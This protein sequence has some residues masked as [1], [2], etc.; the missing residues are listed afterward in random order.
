MISLRDQITAILNAP[1]PFMVVCVA[2]VA[3]AWGMMQW[4]YKARIEKTKHLFD[5]SRSEIEIK[6]EIAARIEEELKSD[7][8]SLKKELDESKVRSPEI[9]SLTEKV[10]SLQAK[11]GELVQAN[12]AVS[13]A[14]SRLDARGSVFARSGF[15]MVPPRR[16]GSG[17]GMVP[18]RSSK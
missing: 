18:P 3:V 10:S 8:E 12:N 9:L 4:L 11:M 6:T 13:N 2:A 7:V 17:L 15:G 1:I 5:L 14:V 16:A